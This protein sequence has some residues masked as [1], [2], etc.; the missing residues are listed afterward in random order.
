MPL[1]QQLLDHQQDLSAVEKFS[2]FHT[3]HLAGPEKKYS[4][5]IPLSL[6]K[7][8]EQYAFEVNLDACTGCKACVVGCHSLNGLDENE[9][10]RKTGTMY[11]EMPLFSSPQT[12][13]TACHHC[14]EPGCLLGC[15]TQAYH[16]DSVTGIVKHLD[17][18]C[19]GC[20]YC[21]LK[22][23]YGVPQYSER[24]GVVRKCDMCSSRLASG[25]A[26][27]CAQSC[28]NEAIKIRIVSQDASERALDQN[29]GPIAGAPAAS[30]TLP[31]TQYVSKKIVADSFQAVDAHLD[32]PEH[33]HWPLVLMLCFTQAG[34][35]VWIATNLGASQL[36]DAALGWVFAFAL[37]MLGLGI[38]PFHLG[39]PLLAYRAFLGFRTSWLSREMLAFGPLPPLA[40]GCMMLAF[41]PEILQLTGIDLPFR[42][43]TWYLAWG[44]GLI[45]LLAVICSA[46]I[47][48][49]TPRT[50]WSHP[51]TMAKFF[52]TAVCFGALFQNIQAQV[53]GHDS[54]IAMMLSLI[55]CSAK[56]LLE[57][58]IFWSREA[59]LSRTA[60]LMRS[61]LLFPNILRYVLGLLALGFI[62]FNHPYYSIAALLLWL[63]G[64][65]AERYLFFRAVVPPR[66]PGEN[67]S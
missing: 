65:I 47:Y 19:F 16:K 58:S 1:L 34:L 61:S 67:L 8:G 29:F 21:E 13:T 52:L 22:C 7:I 45:T 54:Q 9:T 17:D 56:L 31:S 23:P 11:S 49:D 37:M 25:E 38:A 10:W 50:W 40:L 5:L 33:A 35:G 30:I 63:A 44:V 36:Q 42:S 15:P 62:F 55:A 32:R 59:E 51:R 20:R 24:L 18:Q 48:I 64:D 2:K 46:M 53:H 3:D 66:M 12:V 27:A 14:V 57:V 6:P 41:Q 4:E 39:R 43:T 28:P 26:P 60:R